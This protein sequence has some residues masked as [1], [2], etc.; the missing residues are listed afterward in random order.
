[1]EFRKVRPT[2]ASTEVAAQLLEAIRAGLF[3]PDTRLPSEAEL[4]QRMGVSRPTV[5]EALSALAAVGL[6][7]A[8]P[9]IGNFVRQPTESLAFQALFILESE[10]SCLEIMEARTAVEP[11]LAEL[12]ARKRT[13]EQ[14]HAL[15]QICQKLAALAQPER[16]DEYFTTDKEFHVLLLDAA[17]NS[18]LTS[19]CTPLINTPV[20]GVHPQV[21]LEGPR[22]HRG[23]SGAARPGGPSGES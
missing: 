18:L 17:H 16:F 14:A 11:P 23:G 13:D 2:K 20:P 15:E 21:L 12:A 5:R 10:A 6:I 4:A 9:G 22:Q 8:R 1:M 3:P 19:I 7:E